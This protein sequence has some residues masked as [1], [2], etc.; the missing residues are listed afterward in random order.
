M[1][2]ASERAT[3][4]MSYAADS[5]YT[6]LPRLNS[7]WFLPALQREFVWGAGQICQLFDSLMRS[8][9]ISAF[10]LWRV[11]QSARQDLEVYRFIDSASDFGKHNV[12][13]R[14]FGVNDLAFV[15][16]G[17]QRL[18]SLLIGLRG[19]YEFRKKYARTGEIQRLHLDLLRNGELPDEEGEISFGFEFRLNT[20][21]VTRGSHW[22]E[23]GRILKYQ[24][25]LDE[26]LNETTSRLKAFHVSDS[27][28]ETAKQNLKAL[29]RVVFSDLPICYHT[30]DHG[31]QE[32]MLDIFV[33]ANSGGEALSKP[34][35]LLS[36]LTVH[37]KSRD[38]RDEMT[39]FVDELNAVL[40]R[41]TDSRREPLKQ[42]F[43]LKSCLVLLDSQ[44][45]YRISSFNK[46]T[47]EQIEACWLDIQNAVKETVE[48]ANWFGI[49]GLNLTSANALVPIAYYLYRNSEVRLRSDSQTDAENA[50]LVRRWLIMALLNSIFGGSSD[51]ILTK[52][53]GVI[54][55]HGE[56]GRLYP[57]RELDIAA[58]DA[59]RL[60]T[61]DPNA[62]K[63]ILDI[64]YGDNSCVLALSL[65]FDERA[66]GTTPHHCD[67]IFAQDLFKQDL[68]Q[69]RSSC[70]QLGNLTLLNARENM[71]KKAKPFDEW[72]R[73]R[74]QAFLKRHL[75]PREESLWRPAA[76][77]DFLQERN[78]LILDRLFLVLGAG[79]GQEPSSREK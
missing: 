25:N 45:A 71:E 15:L 26:L 21:T 3:Y 20:A 64:E 16:D 40:N 39:R 4:D 57:V 46:Q 33:R 48:V 73:T 10:L 53:R 47:C 62:I 7:S 9:P 2:T 6:V 32:R 52:M 27:E 70:D 37:W 59:R 13:E 18:T 68:K 44:V 55:K 28:L 29:H 67:H 49:N 35:L 1:T 8:Y 5:I 58:R 14:A 74:E 24:T 30:E 51:S 22:F 77:P 19:T 36:N 65:L 17:Q 79:S 60:P 69:Y 11:P 23:V 12:R 41:G 42:D 61:T 75:I 72:I 31:D 50:T 34:E 54:M 56:H 38:A 43:V 78:R 76:F 63:K 66:W